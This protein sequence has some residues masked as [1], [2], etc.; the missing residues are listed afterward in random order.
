MERFEYDFTSHP[1]ESFSKMV[2]FCSPGG[3]CRLSDVPEKEPAALV[4]LLNLRGLDGWELIQLF[5]GD[6]GA[7]ACWKRRVAG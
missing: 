3:E 7:I 4:E 6:D 5:F 1:A 2:Y